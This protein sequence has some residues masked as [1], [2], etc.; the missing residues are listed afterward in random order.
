MV[1]ASIVLALFLLASGWHILDLSMSGPA[2]PLRSIPQRWSMRLATSALWLTAQAVLIG[3][4]PLIWRRQSLHQVAL[5]VITVLV[6]L[7]S[8]ASIALA[9]VD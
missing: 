8:A 3:A 7:A 6:V 2:R 4:L 9:L 1:G 5:K